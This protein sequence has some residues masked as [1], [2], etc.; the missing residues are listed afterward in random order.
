MSARLNGIK[1]LLIRLLLVCGALLFLFLIFEA[2]LALAGYQI[3]EPWLAWAVWDKPETNFKL[4][5]QRIWAFKPL[6]KNAW[7][8]F[9]TDAH[10]LRLDPAITHFPVDASY[11]IVL[12]G[13]SFTYGHLV[14]ASE[15]VGERLQ[16]LLRNAG[17]DVQVLNAGVGGYSPGQEFI[18]LQDVIFPAYRPDLVLWNFSFGD[19]IDMEFR[20][21]HLL[22]GDRLVRI[23]G[24]THGAYVAGIVQRASRRLLSD[25]RALNFVGHL[26]CDF[27]PLHYVYRQDAG[28]I[29]EVVQAM[30]AQI[31]SEARG[32]LVVTETPSIT[33]LSEDGKPAGQKVRMRGFFSGVRSVSDYYLPTNENISSAMAKQ[34]N[35]KVE[36]LFFDAKMDFH[37]HLT[38]FGN[39]FYAKIL[40][41]YL[42]SSGVARKFPTIRKATAK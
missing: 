28:A 42:E 9:E 2:S 22:L 4:D 5:G 8:R 15:A 33:M 24:W 27:D 40:A 3:H 25:S 34:R 1:I 20:S 10:G 16:H 19:S 21:L 17:Y 36:E 31:Q 7:G 26:M 14:K 32:R 11:R 35:I 39:E 38:P 41:E 23:P 12:V 18:F 37:R 6:H 29:L 30:V 13:D